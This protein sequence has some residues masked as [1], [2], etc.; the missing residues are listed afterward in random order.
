[1]CLNRWL[2][3]VVTKTSKTLS[4]AGILWL[5]S[6]FPLESSL[7]TGYNQKAWI[8]WSQG[9]G[10]PSFTG[11]KSTVT[12]RENREKRPDRSLVQFQSF[13]PCSRSH[14]ACSCL[15]ST[16]EPKDL[17]MLPVLYSWLGK[18]AINELSESSAYCHVT[19]TNW[20]PIKGR[21]P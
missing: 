14:Y 12:E 13:S 21:H 10:S 19:L 3:P 5:S 9:V 7:V 4:S 1:M 8:L 17:V 18:V 6:Q 2:P 16:A 20:G 15:E 11:K